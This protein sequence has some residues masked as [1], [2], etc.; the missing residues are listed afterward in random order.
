MTTLAHP[1]LARRLRDGLAAALIAGVV[2]LVGCSEPGGGS[3]A[4]D[5]GRQI[6]LAQCIACHNTDPGAAGPVGP[7]VRGA[8]QALLAAKVLKGTYPAGYAPKRATTLMPPQPGLEP[9]IPNL[10]AFL[11]KK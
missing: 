3:P 10:A 6:Y 4:A 9:E 2:V 11:E 7:P 5:R 8:S 1:A